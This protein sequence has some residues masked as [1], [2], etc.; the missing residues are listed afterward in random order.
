MKR[1][2]EDWIEDRLIHGLVA[3]AVLALYLT[4][5]GWAVIP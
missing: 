4:L 3:L 1:A 5:R 2:T